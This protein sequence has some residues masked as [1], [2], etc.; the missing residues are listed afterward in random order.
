MRGESEVVDVLA[1]AERLYLN[2]VVVGELLG[3]FAAGTRE[4]K[5]RAEGRR[6]CCM[7]LHRST[8]C[9]MLLT[10]YGRTTYIGQRGTR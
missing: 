10:M 9:L 4:A 1:H 5:N 6:G 7:N 3:G 2:S 8:C